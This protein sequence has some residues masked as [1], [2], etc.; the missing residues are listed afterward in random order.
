MKALLERAMRFD[1]ADMGVHRQVLA[2]QCVGEETQRGQAQMLGLRY[3]V[4][5]QAPAQAP[6]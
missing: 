4:I 5:D 6:P 2:H 3:R 1:K